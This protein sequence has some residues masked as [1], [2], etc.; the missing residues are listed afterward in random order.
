MQLIEVDPK[1]C[2]RWQFADRSGFEFGDIYAL[3]QDIL[4]HGQIEPAILRKSSPGQETYEVIAGSRRWKACLEVNIPLKGILQDLTDE[5]AAIVQI[6]ENQHL[7]LCD[8][9]RGMYYAKLL[10]EN[11]ITKTQLAD[12]I[13]CSRAKLDNYLAF[14]K[15]PSLIWDTVGNLTRVSSRSA[16]AILSL[17]N[18]GEAYVEALIE[19]AD[20]IRKGAGCKAIEE[21]VLHIVTGS[22]G[23]LDCQQKIVLPSGQSIARWT[24]KGLEFEK[25]LPLNQQEI[26]QMLIKYFQ[27][28]LKSGVVSLQSKVSE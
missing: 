1:L 4:K 10:K 3:S 12:S 18:K 7:P 23:I 20:D 27:T 5:Q 14:D 19:I 17:A 28:T 2:Q 21:K 13:G 15:V 11:K 9:S 25:E 26:A 22:K 16:A 6:K 24:K 8:Y